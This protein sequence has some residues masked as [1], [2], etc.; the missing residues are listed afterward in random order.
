MLGGGQ[1]PQTPLVVVGVAKDAQVVSV[2]ENDSNY[3]YLAAAPGAGGGLTLLVRSRGAFDP[4][5]SAVRSSVRELDRGLIVR[6][7]RLEENLGFWRRLS[8]LVSGPAGSLSVL[9]LV[10]ASIG[11]YGVVSYV[12]S[13][14][15]REVGI[16]IMLGATALEVQRM[17]LRQTLR[18]VVIGAAV[19]IA[20]AAAAS[21]L[22]TSVL[23]GISAFDP[24]AFVGAPLFLTCVAAAA[25]L[26][27]IRRAARVDPMTTLRA[28]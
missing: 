17:I 11:V 1:G 9:A 16:R 6:V 2:A 19:G 23:F 20:M 24:I 21:Q 3:V 22:L 26:P 12:V 13:R 5:A 15:T 10:L 18:P 14:R 7:T 25:S 27:P 4:L 8:G 28:E